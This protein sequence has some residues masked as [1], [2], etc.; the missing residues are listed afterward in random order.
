MNK[1]GRLKGNIP[2]IVCCPRFSG[3]HR[4][5]IPDNIDPHGLVRISCDKIKVFLRGI[6]YPAGS[7]G[8]QFEFADHNIPRVNR[9]FVA[10][11]LDLNGV[12]GT[13]LGT[14]PATDTVL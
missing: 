8:F 4:A 6:G 3:T 12:C 11:I 14:G 13:N 10:L 9:S 2:Y 7:A 5:E 1:S